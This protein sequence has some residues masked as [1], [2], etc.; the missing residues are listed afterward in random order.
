[1]FV[2]RAFTN[3]ILAIEE[4]MIGTVNGR[5]LGAF[6]AKDDMTYEEVEDWIKKQEEQLFVLSGYVLGLMVNV[7]WL[8]MPFRHYLKAQGIATC[9]YKLHWRTKVY[10]I[11]EGTVKNPKKISEGFCTCLESPTALDPEKFL[12]ATETCYPSE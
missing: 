1:M 3:P 9:Y 10:I 5:I 12:D 4:K 6:I 7:P 11:V 2:K 8:G